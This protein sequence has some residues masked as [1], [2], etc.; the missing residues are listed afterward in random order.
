MTPESHCACI[1]NTAV[2]R[3][4]GGEVWFVEFRSR[5]D[6]EIGRWNTIDE[7]PKGV[8]QCKY[9]SIEAIWWIGMRWTIVGCGWWMVSIIVVFRCQY[10]VNGNWLCIHFGTIA[11][12]NNE[13][14]RAQ[15]RSSIGYKGSGILVPNC[16]FFLNYFPSLP[17]HIIAPSPHHSSFFHSY[18][19]HHH[20]VFP[21]GFSN[22]SN[23]VL[24]WIWV[25]TDAF[26]RLPLLAV[27]VLL[28]PSRCRRSF[29][30]VVSITPLTMSRIPSM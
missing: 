4:V 12:M 15:P 14:L 1:G 24:V 27:P 5:C 29:V 20:H 16:F 25:G 7:T 23:H 30:S 9:Q 19:H 13:N 11:I 26:W 21:C 22:S 6:I 17:P 3:L 18:H 8:A 10:T 28:P 2:G